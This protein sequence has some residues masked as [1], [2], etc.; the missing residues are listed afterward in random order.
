MSFDPLIDQLVG[1]LKPVR[2]RRFW[3]DAAIFALLCV[4]E[5]GVFFALGAALPDMPMRMHQPTFW[6]RLVSL[7]LIAVIS[8]VPAILSFSPTYSP[9]RALRWIF[10]V[11]GVCLLTGVWF[12]IGPDE[13][14]SL[15]RRIDWRDGIQCASKMIALSIPPMVGLGVLMRRGAPSDRAKSALLVGVAAA[16]WGAFV[17]VF[18]CPFNDPLYIVVWYSV[19]CGAV[20]LLSRALLP[21]LARW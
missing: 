12:N 5:I 2:P 4:A 18:A 16:A 14:G 15:V 8:S 20:T 17:F 21:H 3:R 7:G 11:I 19:G 6:W 10:V 1:N 13:L 9:R